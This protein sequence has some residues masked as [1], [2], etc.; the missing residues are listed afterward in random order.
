M[1]RFA[2]IPI[3]DKVTS[4]ILLT[5]CVAILIASGVFITGDTIHSRSEL[6]RELSTV[7]DITG[8]NSTAA[9]LF[10][11][12]TV[13]WETLSALGTMPNIIAAS[14]VTPDDQVFA[15]YVP[16]RV[17]PETTAEGPEDRV[18]NE[19]RQIRAA[20]DSR[21]ENAAF[22]DGHVS[23]LQVIAL[24]GEPIGY[25][26]LSAD[27]SYIYQRMEIQLSMVAVAALISFLIA[28]LLSARLQ[29]VIS[30]P[31]LHLADT[32]K[33]VGREKRY[34]VR[35]TKTGDD[36]LGT[37][38]DGFNDMLS[39]IETHEESIAA[40]LRAEAAN[41][42]KSE[43][44]AN[45]SH[46]LRTPL[47]A[48]IGFADAMKG[49]VFGTLGSARY[50]SYV[51]DIHYSGNHLLNIINDILDLSK[52]ESGRIEMEETHFLL[53]AVA[54]NA[55]RMLRERA[56][57]QGVT[58]LNDVPAYGPW[59]YGDQRLISQVVI[60]LLSNAVKF[61]DKGGRVTIAICHGP[62]GRCGLRIADTGIGIAGDDLPTVREPFAQ[63]ANAFSRR[64]GGTGL[65]LPLA[66]QI[67]QHHGGTLDLASEIGIGT[68]VTI[69][70]P[71]RRVVNRPGMATEC[72]AAMAG[73]D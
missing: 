21:Y 25:V 32:M 65:G 41:R 53:P 72:E 16:D 3:Q 12:E 19:V 59:L 8:R 47:N 29:K 54:N 66:D 67:M 46:E 49:E 9:V 20:T 63:V 45:M 37:L 42:A 69:W 55:I 33:S 4:I 58:V 62:A 6:V 7:A 10:E 15:M 34:S 18:R 28:M 36:E 51:D 13:A 61:T 5:S 1:P 2:D 64:H 70:F 14:I 11:D 44:L 43:F 60:N 27:L 38:I 23:V 48:I 39:Q 73:S 26:H 71:A 35:A 30:R 68:T 56:V 22:F 57:S 17:A 50:R 52:A 31:I 40:G 24:D